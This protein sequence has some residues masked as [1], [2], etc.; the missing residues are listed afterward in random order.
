[1]GKIGD[2]YQST[3][4]MKIV[5]KWKLSVQIQG[6]LVGLRVSIGL[7]RRLC[8]HEFQDLELHVFLR[9]GWAQMEPVTSITGH[10]DLELSWPYRCSF[11]IAGHL[12]LRLTID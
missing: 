6:N 3:N 11:S 1:M 7:A 5:T 9:G 4:I 12:D 10:P 2:K 8:N